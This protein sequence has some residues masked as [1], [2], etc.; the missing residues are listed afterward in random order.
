MQKG[1]KSFFSRFPILATLLLMILLSI[2]I[3]FGVLIYLDR[4]TLHGESVTIPPLKGK[5]LR[6]VDSLLQGCGLS[7][8]VVDS[9][10][11]LDRTPGSVHEVVPSEGSEVKP[12]RTIYITIVAK[13]KPQQVMPEVSNMSMRQARATLEGLGFTSISVRYIPGDFDNLT[14]MVKD[15]QGRTLSAGSRVSLDTPLIL[16]VSSN[17]VDLPDSLRFDSFTDIPSDSLSLLNEELDNQE[18]RPEKPL[19]KEESWW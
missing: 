16:I 4:Y 11:A 1:K 5:A 17:N 14:Q 9:I 10:Y 13:E 8:E 6:E 15:T 19:E 18:E 2:I 12:G 7:F 3:V